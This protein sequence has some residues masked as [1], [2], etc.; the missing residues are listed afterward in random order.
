VALLS[1]LLSACGSSYDPVQEIMGYPGSTVLFTVDLAADDEE[2][3]DLSLDVT[4]ADYFFWMAQN[5]D[6]ISSYYSMMGQE[7]NW[8]DTMG[9]SDTM[10]DYVKSQAQSTAVIYAIAAAKADE[11]GYTFTSDDKADYQEEL[12]Q[13]KE[14]LGGDEAYETYLKTMCLTDDG[15]EQLSSVG[16]VYGH[17]ADGLC[18]EGGQYAPTDDELAAYV[19]DNDLLVAKHILFM[20]IDPDTNEALSDE[21]KAEKLSQAEDVLAQLQAV[22]DSDDLESTFDELMNEYS[23]DTGLESNP[24]GYTFTSGDM[25][26][27]FEDATRALE[28]GQI[29]DIVESD[30]GYHIILRLDPLTS[31]SVQSEWGSEKLSELLDGWVSD[32]EIT[33]TETYDEL[34]TADFYEKL[35]AYR[36]TL[37]AEEETE[38]T[39]DAEAVEDS[40]DESTDTSDTDAAETEEAQDADTTEDADAA[41]D[42]DAEAEETEDTSADTA[43][44]DDTG[45]ETTE[46]TTAAEEA[47]E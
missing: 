32:A 9:S 45:A 26:Q 31:A 29:S 20:T 27:E 40:T 13:A 37:E 41:E 22:E 4:A 46:D 44:A 6:Q 39:E 16:V 11:A 33:T 5:A 47:A 36:D 8:D 14:D 21:E 1:T 34:T 2:G 25:V 23:E 12:D 30:Y 18:R 17:M 7:L 24:D 3:K 42:T 28:P 43:N 15:M 19:E 10:G 35:T 38:D